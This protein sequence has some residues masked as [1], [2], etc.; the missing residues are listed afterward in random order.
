VAAAVDVICDDIDR[1]DHRFEFVFLPP[2]NPVLK[3]SQK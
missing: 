1:E 2:P 3:P